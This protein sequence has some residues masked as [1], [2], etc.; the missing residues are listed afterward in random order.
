[1]LAPLLHELRLAVQEPLP[2]GLVVPPVLGD[3]GQLA[4]HAGLATTSRRLLLVWLLLRRLCLRLR[5]LPVR[6][7]VGVR[8]LLVLVLRVCV[9]VV[10]VATAMRVTPVRVRVAT[11]SVAV[12]LRSRRSGRSRRHGDDSRGRTR[13]ADDA[14]ICAA[15]FG[16][17]IAAHSRTHRG[18]GHDAPGGGGS[19][20]GGSSSSSSGSGSGSC[21]G[22]VGAVVAVGEK[23]FGQ[24]S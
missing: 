19:G 9:G 7:R 10:R 12:P 3:L 13:Q 5:G 16:A 23:R 24:L 14:G 17:T 20:S 6:V 8:R 1:V 2:G 4:L 22:R 21:C 15:S 11:V 18:Q